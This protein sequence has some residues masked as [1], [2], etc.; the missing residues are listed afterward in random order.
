MPTAPSRH[1]SHL[2]SHTVVR[3]LISSY[4]MALGLGIIPGTDVGRLARPFLPDVAAGIASGAVVSGL[5]LCILV[6]FHRRAAA[7]LL[8]IVI[9]WASYLSMLFVEDSTGIAG[10]WRDLALIGALILTYADTAHAGQNDALT[11]ISHIPKAAKVRR[12]GK[13]HAAA[14]EGGEVPRTPSQGRLL[15]REDLD[16]VRAS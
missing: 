14:L 7:L 4:F 6:G 13:A 11:V 1:T 2:T 5:A 10:F 9:F 3:L 12:E 16:I 8:A 15:Y